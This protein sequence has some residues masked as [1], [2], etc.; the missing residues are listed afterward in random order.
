ML[1]RVVRMA[2]AQTGITLPKLQALR[3]GLGV[4]R[5]FADSAPIFRPPFWGYERLAL[6]LSARLGL[7]PGRVIYPHAGGNTPQLLVNLLGQAI[8][9]GEIEVALI[10]GAEAQ[11][12]QALAQKQGLVLPWFDP[13][14]DKGST[15]VVEEV[16]DPRPGIT[17]HE[18]AHGIALP[19]HVYPLFE[20]AY[21]AHRSRSPEAHA[22]ALGTLMAP[23]TK[24]AAQNPYAALPVAR[25]AQELVS[26]TPDNRMVAYPYTKYLNAHLQV[27]QAACVVLMAH[28]LADSLGIAHTKRVYLQ[29]SAD[30]V[31]KFHVSERVNYYSSPA[32]RA[33]AAAALAQAEIDLAQIDYFDLYSC[34]PVA[35]EIGADAVGLA[36]DDPRGLTLTGGLPYFGGPGNNY[37]LHA[38]VTLA[39]RLCA[40]HAQGHQRTGFISGNGLYLTKH[41]FGIYGTHPPKTPWRYQ[42]PHALQATLDGLPTPRFTPTPEGLGRIETFSIVYDKNLPAYA[43][44]V[45]RQLSDDARFLCTLTHMED[46]ARLITSDVWNATISVVAHEGRNSA[47][48][49]Q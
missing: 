25:S 6:S 12:T 18:M 10:V 35:V 17:R 31:D 38:L 16:G 26:P 36:H 43:I 27:D 48:F 34:F 9:Q 19:A 11:R 21:G 13:E 23:F 37:T 33:G 32:I 28:T 45:G 2:L 3:G 22:A 44:I 29:G 24:V 20:N 8:A 46:L 14:L 4:V 40:D 47:C 7:A 39:Q 41:S 42:N 5:A 30:S 49:I 1:E 15:L